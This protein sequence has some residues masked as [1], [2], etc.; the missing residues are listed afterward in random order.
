MPLPPQDR[1]LTTIE[2]VIRL[3]SFD[4][5]EQATVEQL[6][7]IAGVTQEVYFEPGQII[8][9]EGHPDDA[10]N[11]LL[12]GCVMLEKSGKPVFEIK[13][14]ETFGTSTALNL[15]PH[16]FSAKA[17]SLVHLLKLNARDFHELLALDGGLALTVL[18]VLCRR[19]REG[20][21][22]LK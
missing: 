11:F 9:E 20:Y 1:K 13:E 3:K 12:S 21:F 2:K 14:R 8:Y 7:R 6:V 22:A 4:I 18:L 15:Q 5:F 10:L 17:S 16:L 19:F